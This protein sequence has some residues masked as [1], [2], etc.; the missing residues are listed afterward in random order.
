MTGCHGCRM[1]VAT[2]LIVPLRGSIAT[3]LFAYRVVPRA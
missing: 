1:P 2:G 3:T